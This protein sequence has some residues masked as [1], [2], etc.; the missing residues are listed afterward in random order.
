MHY[1]KFHVA[2]FLSTPCVLNA[3]KS[4]EVAPPANEARFANARLRFKTT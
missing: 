1:F 4:F 3:Q 2:A